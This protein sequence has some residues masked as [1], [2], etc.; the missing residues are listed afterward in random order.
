[1]FCFFLL[2]T[3]GT[4][5]RMTA[6][7]I[8]LNVDK[9]RGVFEYVVKF[10]PIIDSKPFRI[11]IL[12]ANISKMGGI[13]IYDG[14]SI[15]FLPIELPEKVT[16]FV[17]Q[18]P[19]DPEVNVVMTVTFLRKKRL[20]DCLQLYNILFKRI[21]HTLL[22][23]GYGRSYF[24]HRGAIL[25]PQHRLEVLPGYAVAV[26]EYEGGLMLCLDTQHRVLRTVNV[27]ELLREYRSIYKERFK[28]TVSNHI[29]GSVILTRYNHKTYVIDEIL[30][31]NTPRD[32]FESYS[33]TKISYLQYYE[34]QH[35]LKIQDVNQ[36]LLLHR[37]SIRVP[38]SLEKVDKFICLVPELCYMTGLT[39]EMR[40][41]FKVCIVD[42][43]V[44]FNLLF[45]FNR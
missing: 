10:E 38:G 37:K 17:S 34:K 16:Q 14:G 29:I 21:M 2:G 12:N 4:P 41:D 3:N 26:D 1:M 22:Y 15:L 33:G 31:D 43:S 35:N 9:D 20:G 23:V 39:D 40:S 18:H 7:Y 8:R 24:N 13:K 28:E 44:Q 11:N 42:F 45:V 27:L 19:N 25:I 32:T 5:V 36:P 6:N 30:W